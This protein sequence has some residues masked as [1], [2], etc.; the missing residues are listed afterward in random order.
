MSLSHAVGRLL[1]TIGVNNTRHAHGLARKEVAVAGHRLVYLEGGEGDTVVFLH[2][3]GSHKNQWGSDLYGFTAGYRCLFLDLPGEGESDFHDRAGYDVERQLSRLLTFLLVIGIERCVLVGA[4]FG[5]YLAGMFAAR[6]PEMVRKLVLI[7]P[8]GVQAPV[9][10]AALRYFLETG[11]MPFGYGNEREMLAYWSLVFHC[12]PRPVRPVRRYLAQCGT[13]RI[14]KVRQITADIVGGGLFEL[15]A[16][17][18]SISAPVLV[19]WGQEDRIFDVS[20]VDVMRKSLRHVD[21]VI[22]PESGHMPFLEAGEQVA[23]VM[24]IFLAHPA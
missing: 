1:V 6:H 14:D 16:E 4:S 23:E 24:R 2:G 8:A 22:I 11:S 7:D 5:G 20:T 19:V 17:L 9:T 18:E 13:R 3:L 10:S 15:Q 12:P 21:V